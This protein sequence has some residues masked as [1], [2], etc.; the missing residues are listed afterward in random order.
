MI[1][2]PTLSPMTYTWA[3]HILQCTEVKIPVGMEQEEPVWHKTFFIF[4]V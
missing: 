1:P 3:C 4:H 2:N